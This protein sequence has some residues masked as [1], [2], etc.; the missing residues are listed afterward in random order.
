MTIGRKARNGCV[1]PGA[2]G[3]LGISSL[4]RR[5]RK[6]IHSIHASIAN[7]GAGSNSDE[8]GRESTACPASVG[9]SGPLS[10]HYHRPTSP[11]RGCSTMIVAWDWMQVTGTYD[12]P[13]Y[14]WI[15]A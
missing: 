5:L 15:C 12:Q 10:S 11:S 3:S 6:S 7:S 1:T 2:I 9:A 13:L 14:L 4:S 8:D